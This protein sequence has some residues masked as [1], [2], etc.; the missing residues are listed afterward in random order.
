M[1]EESLKAMFKRDYSYA[2][3][4]ISRLDSFAGLENDL[5][6]AMSVKKMDPIAS[7]TYRLALDGSRRIIEYSRN[8]AEVTLN[9]TIEDIATS[10]L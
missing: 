4:I 7:S 6:A 10:N 2:D 9:R 1:L 3:K 8:I 5:L